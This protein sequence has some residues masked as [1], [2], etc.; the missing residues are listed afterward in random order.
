MHLL[1]QCALKSSRRGGYE[2]LISTSRQSSSLGQK[3]ALTTVRN[4]LI[5][6]MLN[7]RIKNAPTHRCEGPKGANERQLF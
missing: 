7:T 1:Q 3:E 4:P 2:V 6:E 5:V